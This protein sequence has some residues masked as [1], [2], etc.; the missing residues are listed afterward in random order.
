VDALE[1]LRE[2]GQVE[3]ADEAVIESAL[4][5]LAE[6][7]GQDTPHIPS[8]RRVIQ[9]RGVITA[10]AVSALAVAGTVA[11]AGGLAHSD[12]P[13]PV[14]VTRSAAAR[15]GG[16][17]RA[18]SGTGPVTAILTAFAASSNDILMV[19]KTMSGDHGTLG[20]TVIWLSPAEPVPGTTVRSRILSFSLAGARQADQALTYPASATAQTTTGPG[21]GTIFSR[22]RVAFPPAAGVR[23]TLIA[24]SYR[25]HVWAKAPVAVQVATVPRTSE[26]R[27]C[28]EDG[29]WYVVGHGFLAGAKVIELATAQGYERL[30]VSAATY[31]PVRLISTG[32]DVDTITFDFRFLPPTAANRAALVPPIPKGFARRSL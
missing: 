6:A 21:C 18:T 11:V 20:P 7:V 4:Q 10:A 1:L 3:P 9:R 8:S 28:L 29:Q 24:V 14:G 31:L 17:P 5:R 23:G 27:T 13:A 22:P 2:L 15:D 25:A 32:P 30:W 19:T 12:M 16:A 26:L